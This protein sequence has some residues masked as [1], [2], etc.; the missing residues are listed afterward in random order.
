[1]RLR[2]VDVRSEPSQTRAAYMT[3]LA[4]E[5]FADPER[6]RILARAGRLEEEDSVRRFGYLV[7]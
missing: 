4:P 3:R 2:Y 1:M 6:R 5:D 7:G